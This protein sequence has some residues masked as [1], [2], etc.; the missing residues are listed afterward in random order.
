MLA[1]ERPGCAKLRGVHPRKWCENCGGVGGLLSM[2][3]PP[4][5]KP[6]VKDVDC[7]ACLKTGLALT[8]DERLTLITEPGLLAEL[9]RKLGGITKE[10]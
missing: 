4:M 10:L 6:F 9:R 1:L 7:P 2:E 5:A 3:Y 8:D